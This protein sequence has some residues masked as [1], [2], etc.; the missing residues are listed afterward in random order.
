LKIG[1]TWVHFAALLDLRSRRLLRFITQHARY[2]HFQAQEHPVIDVHP[3]NAGAG[4]R[5]EI[6][7]IGDLADR[8]L[9]RHVRSPLAV[10]GAAVRL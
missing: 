10:P 7:G 3:A 1:A 2:Q 9:P 4:V 6:L 5:D 8:H